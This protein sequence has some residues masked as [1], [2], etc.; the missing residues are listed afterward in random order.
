VQD[1]GQG[2]PAELRPGVG[3]R[4]MQERARYMNA[5]LELT[6]AVGQGLLLKLDLPLPGGA[7]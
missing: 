2:L 3:L 5:S 1:N 6:S 4:S 7:Q